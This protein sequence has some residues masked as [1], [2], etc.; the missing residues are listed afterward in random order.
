LNPDT[1]TSI[2]RLGA[3][4]QAG[5]IRRGEL[6]SREVIEAHLARIDEVN[7]RL[8]ALR[9]VLAD[10]ALAD[11]DEADRRLA[12]GEKVGPLHGVPVS[13]KE[14]VDVGGTATTWG[15]AA[16]A[17]SVAAT[18]APLVAHLRAAGAIPISRGNMPDFAM[19]WHTNSD[20][21]GPTL[22]P[23]DAARTPGG[24]SG[25]EAV[26]LATGMAP[27]GVGNDIGGS[28]RF[29]SQCV[30]TAALRPS[31]GRIADASEIF[32]GDGPSAFQL[33]NSQG[34]MARRVDDV[35][36]AFAVMI[37]PDPR[38]PWHIPAPVH[39]AE[40][41]GLIGV[42]VAIPD[43]TDPGVSAGVR[44]AAKVLEAA[45][46]RLHDEL[47]PQLDRASELYTEIMHEDTRV[48]WPKLAPLASEVARRSTTVDLEA[49]EPLD[50]A[51]YV[52]RWQERRSLAREWSQM[53]ARTPLILAPVYTQPPFGPDEDIE[54]SQP[55]EGIYRGMR[56]V[57]TVNLFSLPAVAVPVGLDGDGLPLGVQIIGPRFREDL[58]LDAAAAI[59]A[60]LGT[61]TPIDPR[62]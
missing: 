56:L 3:L 20:V 42:S 57:V 52:S 45:G 10:A 49:T 15:V 41:A 62:D 36:A 53:Q 35:Q 31:H 46:Y 13:I 28:L 5:A 12:R 27:L 51:G 38:D 24:S 50:L 34:P 17:D 54:D 1:V 59:E 19:R 29:P 58:C 43:D 16:M 48:I 18:D 37:A 40:P 8:G 14:N 7:P 33:F 4:E 61:V 30:G 6:S 55:G 47:P 2:C 39:M 21:M 26:A 32:P 25:G 11:A 60:E 9:V 23:W 44:R 22:N